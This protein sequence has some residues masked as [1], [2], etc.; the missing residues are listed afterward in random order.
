MV[1]NRLADYRDAIDDPNTFGNLFYVILQLVAVE[2]DEVFTNR[3]LLSASIDE[4]GF[5][6]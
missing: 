1:K 4:F 5:K 2:I 3:R 6:N